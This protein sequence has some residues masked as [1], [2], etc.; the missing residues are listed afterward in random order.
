MKVAAQEI[1]AERLPKSGWKLNPGI[2]FEFYG[3]DF[4]PTA[5]GAVIDIHIPIDDER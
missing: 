3:E 5:P 4:N 1:W 2:D